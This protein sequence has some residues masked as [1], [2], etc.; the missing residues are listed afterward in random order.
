MKTQSLLIAG[1]H[2]NL[3]SAAEPAYLEGLAHELEKR[4][5][6]AGTQGAGPMSAAL[7]AGLG[8][9]DELAKAREELTRL[10]RHIDSRVRSLRDLASAQGSPD[11]VAEEP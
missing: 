1:Q 3:R 6:V 4:I 2:L 7:M 10:R 8:L 9:A 11:P 5:Q